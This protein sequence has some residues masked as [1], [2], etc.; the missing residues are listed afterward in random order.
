MER[1]KILLR[2]AT[3]QRPLEFFVCLFG[4][5]D[6]RQFDDRIKIDGIVEGGTRESK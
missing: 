1:N 4:S 2:D 3:N 5:F 6:R